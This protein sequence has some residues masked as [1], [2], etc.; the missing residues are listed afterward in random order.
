[1]DNFTPSNLFVEFYDDAVEVTYRSE[2]EGRPVYENRTFVRIIVPGDATNIIETIATPQHIQ[3][4][5]RQ[6]ERY[7][8]GAAK[9]QE[10]TPLE[11]W[12]PINKAQVKEAKY[13]EIHTVEQ[14]ASIS[15]GAMMK[16]GMGW[17]DLRNKAQAYLNAAKDG[18][19]VAQ[20]A[21]ENKRLHEEIEALKAQIAALGLPADE[22][23]RR[24]RPRKETAEA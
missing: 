5:P 14:L 24:G 11:M 23:P 15:D 8:Q 1:M 18:A 9:V 16:M 20:Q 12:P 21:A 6:Y 10:G 22:A 4:F 13:F 7:K 19:V 17:R 3:D 2:A